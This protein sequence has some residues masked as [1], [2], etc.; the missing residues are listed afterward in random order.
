MK[1]RPILFNGEMVRAVLD[2]RK[3]QTRRVI[4]PQPL[5]QLEVDRDEWPGDY[6]LYGQAGD[7][8]WV[9]E[10]WG[11]RGTTWKSAEPLVTG[12]HIKYKADD[13][14]VTIL[15]DR[16]DQRGIPQQRSQGSDEEEW[17]YGEYLSHFWEQWRPSIHMSRWMSRI[18]LE[19]T[20][21]RVERVQEISR[22]DALDEGPR[23]YGYGLHDG[24]CE[25]NFARLWDSINDKRGFGWDVNPWVW[26]VEFKV[27]SN[28]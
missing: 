17:E 9:R 10:T 14:S 28:G 6:C 20:D 11:F 2:G 4:K 21:V 26:V 18:L 19:I 5:D 12:V 23:P 3:T 8:L 27:V 7:Q 25:K 24:T 13:A 1:E 15:R 22:E 16:V